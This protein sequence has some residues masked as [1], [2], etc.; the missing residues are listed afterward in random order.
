MAEYSAAF[1]AR[2]GKPFVGPQVLSATRMAAVVGEQALGGRP[3]RAHADAAASGRAGTRRDRGGSAVEPGYHAPRDA[4]ARRLSVVCTRSWIS[5]AGRSRAGR[6]KRPSA[7]STPP[8]RSLRDP[9]PAGCARLGRRPRAAPHGLH[10]G[11]RPA[12]QPVEWP[13][14]RLVADHD[15]PVESGTRSAVHRE[16][17]CALGPHTTLPGH[18]PSNTGSLIKSSFDHRRQSFS[19]V[20]SSAKV[21][22]TTNAFLQ[23]GAA[24][25]T[26]RD[27]LTILRYARGMESYA[28]PTHL[29]FSGLRDG[30]RYGGA[31]GA[32]AARPRLRNCRARRPLAPTTSG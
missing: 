29:E 5:G 26:I 21:R 32:G 28:I 14:A 27:L 16:G 23:G 1:E 7:P 4:G 30:A 13:D 18:S 11:A 6:C 31:T 10:R 25:F 8:N 19:C 20:L 15:R 12:A 3:L 24:G 17:A 22:R 2:P 9:G